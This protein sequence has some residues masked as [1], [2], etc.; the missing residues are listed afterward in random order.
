VTL[1]ARQ[2][3]GG[4]VV[5]AA[6]GVATAL[7]SPGRLWPCLLHD[8]F[9]L[10]SLAVSALF[11]LSA[12]RLSGA[13]W[14]AG[15]RRVPEAFLAILPAAAVLM[16]LVS[17]FGRHALYPWTRPGAVGEGGRAIYLQPSFVLA[18]MAIV[19]LVWTVFGWLFRRTSLAQDHAP[20]SGLAHHG[21]LNRLAAAF[22]VIFAISFTVASY[23][24]LLSLDPTWTSTM[25][26]VY[27]F[28]GTFVQGIAA[29]TVAVVV[30]R[31]RGVLRAVSDGQLHDLGK[32]LF[33]FSTFWAYIW[34]CQYLLIWY[35]NIPEEVSHYLVRTRGPWRPLFA[36]NLLVNWVV[37]FALLLSARAK[38]RPG[39]LLGV[40]T[41]LLVGHWI[42]LYLLIMPALIP[43]PRLGLPEVALALAHAAL[44]YALVAR[45]L[46]GAPPVPLADPILLADTGAHS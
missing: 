17:V 23:D 8:G 40:A 21:R 45:G 35:G 2:A 28:A 33:A 22:A 11:F 12:Q 16:M 44:G 19:L 37:P 30:L 34:T 13:R 31:R 25:F 3:L 5:F 38:R 46:A 1:R 43:A 4:A 27:V 32:L 7:S 6:I 18:R 26:A 14:S 24:W 9:Y 41:L 20:V 29:V 15:L 39:M 42:D 36:A 10:L